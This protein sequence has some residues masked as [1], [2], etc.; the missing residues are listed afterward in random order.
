MINNKECPFLIGDLINLKEQPN[1]T[2]PLGVVAQCYWEDLENEWIVQV[3]NKDNYIFTF[4]SSQL[5]LW[6]KQLSNKKQDQS[7]TNTEEQKIKITRCI[8]LLIREI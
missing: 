1:N 5:R 6:N 8:D 2:E 4:F 7:S 3:F